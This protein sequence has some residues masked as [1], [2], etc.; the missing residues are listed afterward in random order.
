MRN[1]FTPGPS[2]WILPPVAGEVLGQLSATLVIPEV[3]VQCLLNRGFQDADSIRSF[4]N[5]RLKSLADPFLLPGMEAGVSRLLQAR[6]AAEPVVIFGDYDA[7]GI[8]AAAILNQFLCDLNWKAQVFLPHRLEEGYGL[9]KGGV[10]KCLDRYPTRLIFA[11]DCGTTACDVV[12]DLQRAG[13]DVV[14]LDHHQL[15]PTLPNACAFINPHV[16][17]ATANPFLNLCSAGLAFKFAHALLKRLREL[18]DEAAFVYDLKPLLDLVAVGSIADLVPLIGENRALVSAGLE[19][20][21]SSPRPGLLA[22]KEIAALGEKI[23]SQDV[24]FKLAPRLNAAGRLEDAT[25]AFDLL[26]AKDIET[27]RPLAEALQQHNQARQ[28][29]ERGIIQEALSAIAAAFDPLRDFI[30]VA[31]NEQWHLGV[32]GIVASRIVREYHRP[33]IILGGDGQVL[34]GSGRSIDGVDLA[35]LLRNSTDLLLAHGGHPMAAGLS[36]APE[37]IVDFRDRLNRLLQDIATPDVFIPKLRLDASVNFSSLTVDLLTQIAK[38]QPYGQGNLVPKFC[39]S[40]LR[41][42][43][44]PRRFGKTNTH[45]RFNLTDGKSTLEMIQ[46]NASP[47]FAPPAQLFDLAYTAEIDTYREPKVILKFLDWKATAL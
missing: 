3:L 24:A 7:D 20:L 21:N 34:R 5:P 46:W 10:R 33:A 17:P 28:A 27:A 36:I 37:R 42:T 39:S 38:L 29:L 30:I 31:A 22:L 8:T 41:L 23:E 11:V 15:G 18:G 45:L 2:R 6:A 4:L 12:E 13:V 40:S 1:P 32:L 14:I 44:P 25:Q 9:S 16:G 43:G 47:N 26:A 35:E 19:R